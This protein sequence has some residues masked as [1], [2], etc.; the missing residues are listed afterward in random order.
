MAVA[1]CIPTHLGG[2]PSVVATLECR[3]KRAL[4]PDIGPELSS[5]FGWLID[6]RDY[7]LLRIQPSLI[8]LSR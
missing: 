2:L 6:P 8:R 7:S 4:A 1:C 5:E 3:L